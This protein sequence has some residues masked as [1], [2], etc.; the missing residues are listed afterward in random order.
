MMLW[1]LQELINLTSLSTPKLSGLR[2]SLKQAELATMEFGI[3]TS[4]GQLSAKLENIRVDYDLISRKVGTVTVSHVQLQLAYQPTDNS[5]VK[6]VSPSAPQVLPLEKLTIESLDFDIHTPWGL[7][8][9]GG[10]AEIKRKPAD[11]FEAIF[12]DASQSIL[13][14]LGPGLSIERA[15]VEA[16]PNGKIFDLVVDHL[17]QP[18]QQVKLH[19]DI[20]PLV[21]WLNTSSLVPETWKANVGTAKLS[22]MASSLSAMQLEFNATSPDSFDTLEGKAMLTRDRKPLLS[23]VLSM[24]TFPRALDINGNLDMAASE[25]FELLKPWR[26]ETTSGWIISAG[27]I[28]GLMKLHWQSDSKSSGTAQLKA[29]NLTLIAGAMQVEAANIELECADLTLPAMIL[30]ADAQ[31]LKFGKAIT[32]DNLTIKAHYLEK[33]LTLDQAKLSMFS[34]LMEILPGPLDLDQHTIPVTVRLKDVD[35]SQLLSSLQYPDISGTGTLNGELPLRLTAD[36][37]ELQDGLLSGISPGVIRYLGPVA[38]N[39]SLAF[40][41]LRNLAYHNLQARVNYLSNGDYRL[42]L[43]LEGSN[44]EVLSGYPLTFSLNISGHLPELLRRGI[45]T[46]DFERIIMEEAKTKQINTERFVKPLT[47][48]PSGDQQ[49]KPPTANRSHQ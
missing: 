14:A 29:S 15:T 22:R 44:P 16:M 45:A 5:R 12:Q 39:E 25:V 37:V 42:G 11:S 41:A 33:I 32:A 18:R 20:A 31:K 26:Q 6:N 9:F 24:A 49:P 10:R 21:E 28:Q 8:R 7:S 35:L 4:V 48:V 23:A 40:S 19:A 34:G 2:F 13:F 17:G 38:D 47:K 3:G 36:T 30:S 27:K 46:G 43:R 1:G